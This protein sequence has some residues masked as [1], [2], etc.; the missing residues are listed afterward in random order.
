MY[1]MI[2]DNRSVPGVICGTASTGVLPPTPCPSPLGPG[3]LGALVD[4]GY[5]TSVIIVT[6]MGVSVVIMISDDV[7]FGANGK[8]EGGPV[9]HPVSDISI[10]IKGT[11]WEVAPSKSPP[12][13]VASTSEL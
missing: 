2:S 13:S 8:L 5:V 7:G 10:L 1:D 11:P 6:M 12:G 9:S 4:L 3:A